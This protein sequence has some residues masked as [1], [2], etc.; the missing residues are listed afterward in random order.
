MKIQNLI[1]DHYIEVLLNS[2]LFSRTR[3]HF[4]FGSHA[5]LCL[6]AV[7]TIFVNQYGE[8]SSS[9]IERSK[10]LFGMVAALQS[11]RY[12]CDYVKQYLLTNG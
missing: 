9:V 12:T 5:Q 8:Y 10:I 3:R 4:Q 1:P 6:G 2:S 7:S 11:L